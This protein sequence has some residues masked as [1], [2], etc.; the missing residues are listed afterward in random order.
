MINLEQYSRFT[1]DLAAR[2]LLY[3]IVHDRICSPL[4]LE[5]EKNWLFWTRPKPS[6]L[7]WIARA[8]PPKLIRKAFLDS[9]LERDHADGI[10]VHYDVSK[11][12]LRSVPRQAIPIL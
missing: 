8:Y 9:R 3:A 12:F 4:P 11:R 1:S 6:L 5:P 10:E 2:G 7:E